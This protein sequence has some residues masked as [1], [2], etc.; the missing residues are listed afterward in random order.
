MTKKG[1]ILLCSILI[2]LLGAFAAYGYYYYNKNTN[3]DTSKGRINS[4]TVEYKYKE[5]DNLIDILDTDECFNSN[6]KV[7]YAYASKK[8]P[9]DDESYIQLCDLHVDIVVN[10]DIDCCL[11][12]KIQDVW[13]KHKTYNAGIKLEDTIESGYDLTSEDTLPYTF[14]SDWSYDK[15]TGYA[16]YNG[17]IKSGSTT[18]PMIIND[19]V[20]DS[21]YYPIKEAK[22]YR[23]SIIVMLNLQTDIVQAN[24]ADILWNR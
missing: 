18:I 23:Q 12:V 8:L 21:Y 5:N 9:T 4:A 11:R 10:T 20:E 17:I 14:D 6:L 15:E 16:Y 19:E 22:G 24:R 1:L 7:L 2:I 13:E 3:I